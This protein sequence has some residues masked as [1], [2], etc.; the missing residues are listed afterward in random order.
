MYRIDLE[1]FATAYRDGLI[2]FSTFAQALVQQDVA[3]LR[4]ET[5]FESLRDWS[6]FS[7]LEDIEE[8]FLQQRKQCTMMVNE[9]PLTSMQGWTTNPKTGDIEHNSGEFY[10]VRGL[11]ISDS[12]TR[13]VRGWDQPILIQVG[14]DGGILGILRKRFHGIPH[15]LIEAKAE[16]GNYE[17]IQMSPTLQATLSNLKQAHGGRRPHFADMFQVPEQHGAQILYKEW[18]SED[19]GR[20]HLK[21]NLG[22]LIEVPD[23]V[24]I[25][26]PAGFQWLSLYQ[27]KACL[28]HNAWVNPHIRGIIAHL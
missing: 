4:L 11:R 18:L 9:I 16:P 25:D 28:K 5:Q 3:S 7:S 8:W 22:M 1:Q 15:Y 27:I 14:L 17:K 19:G 2:K 12:R 26:V 6:C 10:S 21:R 23:A 24:P 13:E 20:L